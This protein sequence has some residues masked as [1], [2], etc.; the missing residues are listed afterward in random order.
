MRAAA[1]S[2]TVKLQDAYIYNCQVTESIGRRKKVHDL[3]Q[4]LLITTLIIW[5][6][7]LEFEMYYSPETVIIIVIVEVAYIWLEH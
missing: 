6:C 5:V 7:R 2:I 4:H 1:A 3:P